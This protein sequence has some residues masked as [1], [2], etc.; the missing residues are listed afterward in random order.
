MQGMQLRQWIPLGY[1]ESNWQI[2][3]LKGLTQDGN[4]AI[5]WQDADTLAIG[6]WLMNGTTVAGGL[7]I[8]LY[9]EPAWRLV[10]HGGWSAPATIDAP[11][12]IDWGGFF[13]EG[14]FLLLSSGVTNRVGILQASFDLTNWVSLTTNTSVNGSLVFEDPNATFFRQRYYRIQLRAGGGAYP[15]LPGEP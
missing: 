5:L 6:A 8:N 14:H 11:P 4:L 2:V 3:G 7:P 15:P 1:V 9:F 13:D 10:G 12:K